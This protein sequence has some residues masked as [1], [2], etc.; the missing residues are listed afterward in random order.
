MGEPFTATM[1]IVFIYWQTIFIRLYCGP[2]W[3]YIGDFSN[4]FIC[5]EMWGLLQGLWAL[6]SVVCM[7]M[8]MV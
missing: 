8:V 6:I 1:V 7:F 3:V 2:Y 4:T 5:V